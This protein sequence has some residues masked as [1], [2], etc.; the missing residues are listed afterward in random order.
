MNFVDRSRP[1]W[2]YSAISQ[3]LRC[4]LQYYFQRVLKL[5]SGTTSSGLILGSAVH[6]GLAA[7]HVRL[8]QQMAVGPTDVLQAY[9][10]EWVERERAETVVYKEGELRDDCIQQGEQ[11]LKLYL[12]EPP[13]QSIVAVE[14]RFM[15]PLKNSHGDFLETPLVAITDLVTS[16]GSELTIQEFKTSGRAY[17]NSEVE[18]SLQPTCYVHAVQESLGVE[19]GVQ[20]TV[21]VKT[22]TPKVQRLTTSRNVS[23]CGRL[24][25]LVEAI[26]RAV[27]LKVFYPVE[28]PLNCSG[29]AYRQQCKEWTSP[30]EAQ[31]DSELVQ[32][33]EATCSLS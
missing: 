32:L 31:S 8:Q 11:L 30:E 22:R 18:T 17:G 19:A 1:H 28:S 20:F 16:K 24:G 4:P 10:D 26:E 3:Y 7:Y 13:P 27:E 14:Q 6:A 23:D 33:T 21:L 25:D 2:S 12:N 5:P 29:C 9:H 15:V